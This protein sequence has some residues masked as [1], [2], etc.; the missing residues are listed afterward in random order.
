MIGTT[1]K[2]GFD[3]QEVKHGLA[4]TKGLMSGFGKEIAIGGARQVGAQMTDWIGK[5]IGMIPN[6][7]KETMDWAGNLVDLSNQTKVSVND[8]M[9][10]GEAFK[11]SG[12]ESVD[13]GKMIGEMQKKIYSAAHEDRSAQDA[14]IGL[15]LDPSSFEGLDPMKR[16]ELIMSKMNELKDTLQPGQLETISS[17]IFGAKIGL[18]TLRIFEDLP[19]AL[20]ESKK[21][22]GD[23]GNMTKEEL[24][25]LDSLGD[26]MGR[27]E[28]AKIK[29][30]SSLLEGL[31]G[32]D[33]QTGKALIDSIVDSLMGLGP[34][35]QNIG[36]LIKPIIDFFNGEVKKLGDM[37]L[38]DYF[39]GVFE[40]MNG[41]FESMGESIGVGF[42]RSIF[43][44]SS[45]AGMVKDQMGIKEGGSSS[46]LM[47]M[48]IGG[49][50]TILDPVG[51][52]K[53]LFNTIKDATSP[54]GSAKL[55]QETEAQTSILERIYAKNPIAIFS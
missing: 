23:V 38:A 12:M 8:L 42:K 43:G 29:L 14:F 7:A 41:L 1:F 3:A 27:F 22:L 55:I 5:L 47:D 31:F 18:K 30:M 13:A 2:L 16:M 26:Y 49:A 37:G 51:G 40:G 34:V 54:E 39:K 53:Q 50:R 32:K 15:G 10:L 45:P 33:M 4:K 52:I 9:A 25:N 36:Q 19:G 6:A 46:F 48:G 21:M 35:L 17:D 24:S 20:A 11:I 28:A 44:G